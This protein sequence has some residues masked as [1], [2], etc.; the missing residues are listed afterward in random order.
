MKLDALIRLRKL[1]AGATTRA[2]SLRHGPEYQFLRGALE[3]TDC[4]LCLS[5]SFDFSTPEDLLARLLEQARHY[6]S[7]AD[8]A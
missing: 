8:E 7:T 3:T 4:M 5:H 1:I 2:G 6:Q